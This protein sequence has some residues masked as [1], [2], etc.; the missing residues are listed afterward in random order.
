MKNSLKRA[1]AAALCLIMIFTLSINALASDDNLE[2]RLKP[3]NS[4]M[5][6][7]GNNINI[8]KP[9][10]K[11]DLLYVPL[12][13]VLEA[14]GAE[15]N[16]LG[17]G[18]INIIYR[19]AYVDITVG[20]TIY[21]V[22]QI[23]KKLPSEPVLKNGTVM[24]PESFITENFGL[25]SSV[26]K[27][28]GDYILLLEDDGALSDLSFLTGSIKKAK[29]GNSYFDWS[30]N[31]PKGS[32]I[33]KTSFNSKYIS[34]ENQHRGINIEVSVTNSS[35]N[36]LDEYIRE[37]NKNPDK[38]L[39]TE[40]I[41]SSSINKTSNPKYGEFLYNNDYYEAVYH[42]V[43][44]YKGNAYNLIITSYYDTDPDDIKSNTYYMG[45]AD[46]FKF[47]YPE[48][49][50]D[51]LDMSKVQ[52]GLSK[53]E[54]YI[55]FYNGNKY[56]AWE[57]NVVP[58]WDV[59]STGLF[60]SLQTKLGINSREYI[61]VELKTAENGISL[62][63]YGKSIKDFYGKDFNPDYYKLSN[64]GLVELAGYKAYQLVYTL[65]MGD[66]DYVIDENYVQVGS[67]LYSISIKAPE[68]KYD[69]SKEMYYNMLQTLKITSRNVKAMAKDVDSYYKDQARA[70]VS[71][72][73][74]I[75]KYENKEY[76]WSINVPGYWTKYEF[77][78][79]AFSMFFDNKS[80]L[81]ICVEAVENTTKTKE[82]G[83][84]EKFMYIASIAGREDAEFISKETID[85]KG[86]TVNV[87]SYR[88]E[89][90]EDEVFA[91]MKF[92]V[93]NTEKYSYCFTVILPD[94]VASKKNIKII[95]DIWDSFEIIDSSL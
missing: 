33:Y 68:Q 80:D 82:Y 21:T 7:N 56:L 26:D 90:E 70:R 13:T 19:S 30:I 9:F 93:I 43:Y 75:T 48:N 50:R 87:Y 72:D 3:D 54:N 60:N 16:W 46:S 18:K 95:Q 38:Y 22:N 45:I 67:F 25:V 74:G 41:L 77:S 57:M 79:G 37:V 63:D 5:H 69:K 55:A 12:R 2:I 20:E 40:E 36:S 28:T 53:Y 15:V 66:R 47:G 62:E 44:I 89:S 39:N 29:I 86:T 1:I 31:I 4:I 10:L 92:Y 17:K 51:I 27:A 94:I 88:V 81:G 73:D 35:G 11:D 59:L 49:S 23:E 32:R 34:V 84:E 76:K 91:D 61:S 24:V 6:V 8:E 64:S 85:Q 78:L 14:I 83:D 58:E 65:K 52:Y 71:K 42:R